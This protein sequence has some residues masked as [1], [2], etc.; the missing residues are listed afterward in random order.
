MGEA[1]DRTFDPEAKREREIGREMVDDSTGL[2]SVMAHFYRGEMDRVTTWR[3]RLDETT[4][5]AVTVIAAVLVYGFSGRGTPEVLLAGVFVTTV[6]LGIEAHRYQYYDVYRSRVRLL[7]ENLFANALDPSAGIEQRD[8]RRKLS[9][10]LREPAIK[11]PYSEAVARRLRRVYLPL[12]FA[13][14]AAWLFRL[15]AFDTPA[16]WIRTAS[17][18]IVPGDVVLVAVAVFYA[19]V[20]WVTFRPRRRHAMEEFDQYDE[21]RTWRK[22]E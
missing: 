3:Q 15:V 12:L 6:F 5:W 19:G 4:K 22:D 17:V 8:W 21:D 16:N 10:D 13:L 11:T 18:G 1:D 14:L 7:Q 9:D 20:V 2:G